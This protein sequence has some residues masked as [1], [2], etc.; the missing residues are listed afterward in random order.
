MLKSLGFPDIHVMTA[1]K[2]SKPPAKER[3]IMNIK[4]TDVE[5][6]R[7]SYARCRADMQREIGEWLEKCQQKGTHLISREAIE[8]VKS[9]SFKEGE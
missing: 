9:G 8:A 3:N 2:N 7:K 4:E 1:G 5:R 6:L